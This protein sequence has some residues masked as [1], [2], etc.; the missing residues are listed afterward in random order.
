MKKFIVSSLVEFIT[1]LR[2]MSLNKQS[3]EPFYFRGESLVHRR[4]LIASGYRNNQFQSEL[5]KGRE[6]Y[7]REI[8]HSLDNECKENFMA[9]SQHHGLPTELLDVTENPLVALYFSCEKDISKN[10]RIYAIEKD[11]STSDPLSSKLYDNENDINSITKQMNIAGKFFQESGGK[12]IKFQNTLFYKQMCDMFNVAIMMDGANRKS[13]ILNS[14]L[15]IC[16]YILKAHTKGI[17]E[18][19]IHRPYNIEKNKDNIIELA[20]LLDKYSDVS[21][22]EGLE[23]FYSD[24]KDLKFVKDLK[25]SPDVNTE[26]PDREWLDQLN[27]KPLMLLFVMAYEIRDNKFPIFPKIIYRPS[28]IFDRLKNQ[29]GAFIYQ[30]STEK[31]MPLNS[32]NDSFNINVVANVVQKIDYEYEIT[33]KNKGKILEELDNIGINRKFIYPDPDNIAQYIKEKNRL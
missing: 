5:V 33:I 4:P 2:E 31:A 30:M 10:G 3:K 23:N 1:T 11:S 7:F 28:I 17:T 21:E 9:Y 18:T 12:Y 24:F 25:I 13:P 27:S 14:K 26:R 6:D 15:K 29:Q 22:K 32:S 19:I 20:N 8:G 16:K